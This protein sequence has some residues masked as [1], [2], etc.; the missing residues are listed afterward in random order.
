MLKV[1]RTPL[2]HTRLHA[3]NVEYRIQETVVRLT[4]LINCLLLGLRLTSHAQINEIMISK[5]DNCDDNCTGLLLLSKN[6][7]NSSAGKKKGSECDHIVV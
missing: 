4:D 5:L 2:S 1:V 3:Y 6:T 7:K